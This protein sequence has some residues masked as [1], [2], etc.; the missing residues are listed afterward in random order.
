MVSL[1]NY[2]SSYKPQLY[3]THLLALCYKNHK[4]KLQIN[5]LFGT[6]FISDTAITT[7]H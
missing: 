5:Y 4:I 2:I 3:I 6:Y 7:K 1:W